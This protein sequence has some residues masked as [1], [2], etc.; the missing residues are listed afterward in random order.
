MGRYGEHLHDSWKWF[1]HLGLL[2]KVLIGSI[3]VVIGLAL[4]AILVS[5]IAT[6]F[7]LRIGFWRPELEIDWIVNVFDVIYILA[8][9]ALYLCCIPAVMMLITFVFFG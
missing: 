7:F 2:D 9:I 4:A 1:L 8:V 3:P 5:A 6:Y